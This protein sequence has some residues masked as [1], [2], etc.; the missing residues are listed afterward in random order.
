MVFSSVTFLI[1]LTVVLLVYF[2]LDHRRQNYFLL[3]ASYVFYGWWDVR[4]LL[5]IF[6]SSS[7]DYFCGLRIAAAGPSKQRQYYVWL[8]LVVNLGFICVFKY[9]NFF[10]DSFEQFLGL[11]GM[12][13]DMPTLR[14]ILPVGISFYTFQSLSYTLDVY[15]NQLQPTR[16]F[17]NY[18]LYVSFFPQLVAG[19]I[20][21]ASRLLPQ[22]ESPR[23]IHYSEITNGIWLIGLGFFK[24]V[25][26]A[27]RLG[28][29]A[30][31]GFSSGLAHYGSAADWIFV[32]A[33]A[34]Q[35][36]GD[37]SGYSD[38]ARGVSKVLGFD[39][40]VNFRAPYLVKSPSAFWQNWH[41]SLSTWLRD[42][43][44]IPLGG[45]RLGSWKTYRNLLLT[46]LLGG[47]WHGAD[48]AFL[49]WGL[50]H[51]L[52]LI[53][54]RLCTAHHVLPSPPSPGTGNR[55]SRFSHVV[56]II[57]FFQVTCFGWLLFRTGTLPE[58]FSQ[59]G[60]LQSFLQASL[61]W[62]FS[63][64]SAEFLQP[65]LLLGAMAMI[66]QWRH[67]SMHRFSQ[68]KPSD[69]AKAIVVLLLL[70]TTLGVF[71]GSQ[72]IYFQF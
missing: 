66:C 70:I 21:R 71:D 29:V 23:T 33:F 32:Y 10:A 5:L 3:V 37:F 60:F 39:L 11:F 57:A 12:Q 47:L 64:D 25:V 13:A 52:I 8:S 63:P 65:V 59:A 58:N 28:A 67:E 46:M 69:Q 53:V 61:K 7:V 72:F 27:D 41:I 42:Y 30:D 68:W 16:S 34:F 15:R 43:L 6:I 4:F 51:G 62:D 26:I 35:I 40:M 17:P 31:Y 48:F 36:Y 45:N 19:P 38:I 24:K 18:L 1:F 55:L 49:L 50:F 54:H 2:R 20:E 14:I 56:G 22:C 44:Y 9:F